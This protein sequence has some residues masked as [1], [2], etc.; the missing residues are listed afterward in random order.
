M[1]HLLSARCFS[2]HFMSVNLFNLYHNLVRYV[3]STIPTL[4]MK[5]EA[6]G[7]TTS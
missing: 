4:Y 6:K 1:E 2:K 5:T 7:L 3:I